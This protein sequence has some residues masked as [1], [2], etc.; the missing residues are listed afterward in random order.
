MDELQQ[1]TKYLW[2]SL[3]RGKLPLLE[4][5]TAWWILVSALD[6]TMTYLLLV[7]PEIHFV[8]SNPIALRFYHNWGF[9]G[10]LGFKLF[11]AL[12][13]ALICQ[14]IARK[15]L[16]LARAVL[17]FGTFVVG[18]VVVYS[19]CLYARGGPAF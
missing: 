4:T 8:E 19:V 1:F 15:K 9:K 13:V 17:V 11:M 5:E 10:L 14:F 12:F 16:E 2:K 3:H 18:C 7:H 6:F